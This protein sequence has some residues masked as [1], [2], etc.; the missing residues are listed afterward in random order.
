M[1]R[2]TSIALAL[3]ALLTAGNAIAQ[4][5]MSTKQLRALPP[6]DAD[7][8]AQ[9]D[10][11]SA[12]EPSHGFNPGML[13][14]LRGTGFT[15]MAYGADY[16]GLCRRD[17]LT[18]LYAPTTHEGRPEDR[19]LKPYGVTTTAWFADTGLADAPVD[20]RQNADHVWTTGCQALDHND[21]VLW[22]T[23]KDDFQAMEATLLFRKAVAGVRDGTLKPEPCPGVIQAACTNAIL[24]M[25]HF[26]QVK[27]C[28]APAGLACYELWSGSGRV[29]TIVFKHGK[30]P[31][32]GDIQSLSTVQYV[33]VT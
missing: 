13:R 21:D 6:A 15:T 33:V 4:P 16:Q 29:L 1:P 20:A 9:S 24:D 27:D 12:L 22:F 18:L 10:L 28:A 30:G 11:S 23:A 32:P 31:A 3:L 2:T 14:A 8:R 7:R 5:P 17:D 25:G 26:N 19:P